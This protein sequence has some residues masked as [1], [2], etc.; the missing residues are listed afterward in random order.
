M[1]RRDITQI[2][3]N[4]LRRI[5]VLT[6][7]EEIKLA[8][9]SAQG[10]AAAKHEMI[11][12]NLRLVVKLARHY[13]HRGIPI[14]DLIEEGNLGLIHAVDKFNPTLGF[15]FSTYATWWI[16]QS[17]ELYIMNQS[18]IVRLPVH[19]IRKLKHRRNHTVNDL[20]NTQPE[21][22]SDDINTALPEAHRQLTPSSEEW[23]FISGVLIFDQ[24]ALERISGPEKEDPIYALEDQKLSEYLSYWVGQLPQNYRQVIV[25]RYGLLGYESGTL[26]E[27]GVN[28]GLTRERV[29]QI[30]LAALK[31]LKQSLLHDGYSYKH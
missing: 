9:Y 21:F 4:E 27:I 13:S 18:R 2:Y 28:I 22:I 23:R 7:K 12:R 26:E 29:R 3:I 1:N 17:I 25:Q 30:Q 24:S 31:C 16:R 11:T 6:P 19:I 8:K 20:K 5:A 14:E 15:R 10:N